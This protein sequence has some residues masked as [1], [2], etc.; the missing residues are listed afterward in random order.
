MEEAKVS[1]ASLCFCFLKAVSDCL[2]V[3][4]AEQQRWNQISVFL[5]SMEKE[6]D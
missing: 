6:N 2:S 3:E 5:T 4:H 1:R